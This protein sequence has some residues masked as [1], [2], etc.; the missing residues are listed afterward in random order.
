MFADKPRLSSFAIITL[1]V[2]V[3]L[4]VPSDVQAVTFGEW[5]TSKR[6]W[7]A[8]Y[9]MPEAVYAQAA[10]IDSLAG[11][12][13]YDWVTTPTRTLFLDGNQITSLESGAFTG[14]AGLSSL[15][16]N[17]NQIASVKP[18]AFLGRRNLMNLDLSGNQITSLESGAFTGLSNLLYLNLMG[19]HIAG[20]EAVD[21]ARLG[22]LTWLDLQSNQITSIESDDFTGL[23]SLT[24]LWLAYNQITRIESGTFAELGILQRLD[25]RFNQITSIESRA[26]AGLSN[27]MIL[28]LGGNSALTYL[29]L[30][31]ADFASLSKFDLTD[32]T[33]ISRVS[34]RNTTL[35]PMALA[36]LIGGATWQTGIGELP[37]IT[38][39]D[40][41][42][43]D[44]AAITDLSPLYLMDHVTD[45]WLADVLHLDA[46]KLDVLLD[47]MA[48]MEDPNI[49]GTLYLTQANYDAYNA[50]GGGKLAKWDAE[51]GH[52]VQILPEPAA[53]VLLLTVVAA[54]GLLAR[55]R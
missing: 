18:G 42:G 55:R 46:N 13:N 17:H 26:F 52:H 2:A 45:L 12:G 21:L 31:G 10:S 54:F 30:E 35:N 24:G 29:N 51:P 7:P 48:A 6:H 22:N 20:L 36:A 23:E 38:E 27:L 40:L 9:V 33:N 11:I 28:D 37:G 19:N 41:S 47:N 8:G 15:V 4:V 49:E 34:L 3:F 43:I 5:A 1:V 16:L 25:L 32:D 39:L 44:F 50:A 53:I 14:L